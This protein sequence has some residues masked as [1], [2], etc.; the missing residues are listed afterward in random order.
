MGPSEAARYARLV[1]EA[2]DNNE[3]IRNPKALRECL[4]TLAN[5][6][7]RKNRKAD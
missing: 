6:I 3:G 7:E 2:L 1:I 5:V 4:D